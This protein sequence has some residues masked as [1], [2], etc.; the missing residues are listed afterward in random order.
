[1]IITGWRSGHRYYSCSNGRRGRCANRHNVAAETVRTKL[2]ASVHDLLLSDA[3]LKFA[4][5]RIAEGLGELARI[6]NLDGTAKSDQ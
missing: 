6:R 1:M 3:G 4:R 2:M 5:K